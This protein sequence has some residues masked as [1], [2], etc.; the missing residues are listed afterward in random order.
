MITLN[1]NI[2]SEYPKKLLQQSDIFTIKLLSFVLTLN[3]KL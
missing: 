3:H 2:E 1:A